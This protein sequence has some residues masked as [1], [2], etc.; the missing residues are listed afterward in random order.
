MEV[1]LGSGGFPC[2]QGLAVVVLEA[3]GRLVHRF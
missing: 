3:A 2:S 1:T